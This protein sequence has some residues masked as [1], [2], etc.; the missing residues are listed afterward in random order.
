VVLVHGLNVSGR[1][2]L[3]LAL[4]LSPLTPV[5]VPDL[6]GFGLSSKPWPP[7]NLP[8][9]AQAL[10]DGTRAMDIE[11][12][13]FFG[14][15]FGCQVITELAVRFPELI[16]HLVLQ[17]P[18]TEPRGRNPMVALLRTLRNSRREPAILGCIDLQDYL[19][20]GPLRGTY[21]MFQSLRDRSEDK[22]PKIDAP[23]LILWGDR[24]TIVSRRWVEHI[25]T[26]LPNGRLTVLPGVT[27]TANFTAS[28]ELVIAMAPFLQLPRE[29]S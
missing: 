6:P 1:Y 7:L 29:I 14:N 28:K 23:T 24:D 9:L 2:M 27:H 19:R 17:S 21:T 3:P 12:A 18:T 20:A 13:H 4:A 8:D 16:D 25:A 15:S 11:K 5:L 26:S 10:H 22:F